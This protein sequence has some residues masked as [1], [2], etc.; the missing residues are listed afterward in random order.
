[1][2]NKKVKITFFQRDT[3]IYIPAPENDFD[4]LNYAYW[5]GGAPLTLKMLNYNFDLDIMC[6]VAFNFDTIDGIELDVHDNEL[7]MR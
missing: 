4:K 6:Y 2:N 1:M 5:Y 3:L 7:K